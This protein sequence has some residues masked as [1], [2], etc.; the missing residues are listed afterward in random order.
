MN[1]Y[2]HNK[3]CSSFNKVA[4][5]GVPSIYSEDLKVYCILCK[6]P[7]YI[8]PLIKQ[9]EVKMSN[10]LWNELPHGQKIKALDDIYYVEDG[11]LNLS[12]D[13]EV[14]ITSNQIANK[15]LIANAGDIGRWDEDDQMLYFSYENEDDGEVNQCEHGI[16]FSENCACDLEFTSDVFEL[17]N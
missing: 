13:C 5:G 10:V 6:Q 9:E 15:I 17:V 8:L 3:F 2:C 4:V 16:D 1:S 14:Y 7:L 11:S 12:E